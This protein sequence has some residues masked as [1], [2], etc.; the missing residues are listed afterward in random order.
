MKKLFFMFVITIIFLGFTT[1][2]SAISLSEKEDIY[3]VDEFSGNSL[4][5]EY[6]IKW[7][8]EDDN[9][10]YHLHETSTEEYISRWVAEL[11]LTTFNL[12]KDMIS[13]KIFSAFETKD[14]YYDAIK[15]ILL[16]YLTSEDVLQTEETKEKT[17][18]EAYTGF[19]DNLIKYGMK[20]PDYAKAATDLQGIQVKSEIDSLDKLYSSFME[21]SHQSEI[22]NVKRML[23]DYSQSTEYTKYLKDSFKVVSAV[24]KGYDVAKYS[25]DIIV[26]LEAYNKIND[27]MLDVLQY[28]YLYSDSEDVSKV[29]AQILTKCLYSKKA[30]LESAVQE[31]Y[32]KILK[33]TAEDLTSEYIKLITDK[34]KVNNILAYVKLGITFGN[35]YSDQQF[36]TSDIREQLTMIEATNEVSTALADM[37]ESKLKLYKLRWNKTYGSY[38]ERANDAEAIIYY[39]KLLLATRQKGEKAYYLLKDTAYSSL[40]ADGIDGIFS[41]LGMN[42]KQDK[43]GK[44]EDWYKNCCEDFETA[45]RILYNDIDESM[46][47]NLY[48]EQTK[49]EDFVIVDGKLTAYN[50]SEVSPCVP[51]DVHTIGTEA[52]NTKALMTQLTIRGTTMEMHCVS[53]CGSLY[54]LFIPKS[55]TNMQEEAIYNCPNVTIYGYAGTVA[56]NYAKSNN[57]PFYS[58]GEVTAGYDDGIYVNDYTLSEGTLDLDGKT[59][60]VGGDFLHTGGTLNIG[61]GRLVIFGNYCIKSE[62]IDYKTYSGELVMENENGHLLVYGNIYMQSYQN[63]LTAGIIEIKGNFMHQRGKYWKSLVGNNFTP[64]GTHKVVLS[65]NGEQNIYFQTPGESFFNDLQVT[66]NTGLVKFESK[67][68]IRNKIIGDIISNSDISLFSSD[69]TLEEQTVKTPNLSICNSVTV[70]IGNNAV[71][72]G[73][74]RQPSGFVYINGNCKITGNYYLTSGENNNNYSYG[75]L[76]MKNTNG[77]LKILGSFK[78][79][80]SQGT[81]DDYLDAISA[82][83][84]EVKKDFINSL[85]FNACGSHK[86]ILSGDGYQEI[87]SAD[88]SGGFNV[89]E[90]TNK[91]GLVNFKS[92]S[93]KKEI[94]G[95]IVSNQNIYLCGSTVELKNQTI[96]APNIYIKYLCDVS[97]INLGEGAK[98]NGNLIHS[99]DYVIVKGKC[100]ISGDYYITNEAKNNYSNGRLIMTDEKGCLLVK[101]DFVMN[102]YYSHGDYLIAGTLDLKGNFIKYSSNKYNSGG[103]YNFYAG[104]T[105]TVILSGTDMQTISGTDYIHFNTL[106]IKNYDNF[107]YTSSYTC[108]QEIVYYPLQFETAEYSK[109]N[110]SVS[111]TVS[112]S[113]ELQTQDGIIVFALYG[114]DN[115]R[116]ISTYVADISE[117]VPCVFENVPAVS[118]N[119]GLGMYYISV[120][121]WSDLQ[122]LKPLC[123]PIFTGIE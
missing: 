7:L 79:C 21:V 80:S 110:N 104:G 45:K 76:I 30:N 3:R 84:M 65:G 101:G 98:I 103:Q 9:F 49:A 109:E 50:G 75:C 62:Y 66:N 113:D 23:Y 121:C 74:L 67:L 93:V 39:S 35:L 54:E 16:S 8:I 102:S 52:F 73:D 51:Y 94:V 53:N 31:I 38:D 10:I 15:D 6:V 85:G 25:Y 34:L 13:G 18:I 69:I 33:D 118:N 48:E 40:F 60:Y 24:N 81:S 59:M 108:N 112:V 17:R 5:K 90:V 99:N 116:L 12:T 87:L 63:T 83:I 11:P 122:E 47:D 70:N 44:I 88:G 68:C 71:I 26:E 19:T 36:S 4:D 2:V 117:S 97:V 20:I 114:C 120:F 29:S 86:V 78:I 105:H 64:A 77:Y 95:D 100:E 32:L 106:I 57:I 92:L 1:T 41:L 37:L 91:T 46:F 43:F 14:D 58:L 27:R 28:L 115:N 111:I 89:L 61:S 123:K 55:V 42:L 22:E 72:D 96:Q 107:N 82:G 56:E 119:H